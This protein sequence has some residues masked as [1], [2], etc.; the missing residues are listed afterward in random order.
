MSDHTE[1]KRLRFPFG[2]HKDELIADCFHSDRQY[3]FWL[4]DQRQDKAYWWVRARVGLELQNYKRIISWML[5]LP[6]AD[7]E[8]LGE[9]MAFLNELEKRLNAG[10]AEEAA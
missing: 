2:T 10:K 3:L 4:A 1:D 8:Y 5:T 9:F 6:G 7:R